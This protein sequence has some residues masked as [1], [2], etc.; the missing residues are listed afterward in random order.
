MMK[1]S[2]QR[3]P[4]NIFRRFLPLFAAGTLLAGIAFFLLFFYDSGTTHRSAEYVSDNGLLYINTPLDVKFTG[5][6]SCRDCHLELYTAFMKTNTARSMYR[7]DTNNIIEEYPQREPVYDAVLDFYYEMI[8]RG[9]KFYQREFRLDATKNVIHERLV[10]AQYVIGSGKNLRMYFYD[11]NG[12]FYELPLTWYAHKKKWDFSPGYKEFGNHRFSRFA[13]SK[14][15]ACHNAHMDASPNALERFVKPYPLG[16]G[17]EA[18]HG[19]GELHVKQELGESVDLPANNARTIVNPIHLSP[20][21]QIDVCQACHL[22]GKAW[23]LRGDAGWFDFRPGMLLEDLWSVYTYDAVH[24][25]EFK[26]ADSGYRFSLSR[27][28]KESHGITT[29]NT[30]HDSHGTFRGTT[31]EFNRQNCQKCHPPESLPGKGSTYAHTERD[32]CVPCH[33]KQTGTKNTLHGVINT[34]HWIRIDAQETTIDWTMHRTPHEMQQVKSIVPALDARDSGASIRKG[35]ALL[36]YYRND[37]RRPVYLDS[38]LAYLTA[39]TELNV[40]DARGF[41]ALGET[42]KELKRLDEAKRALQ[43][44]LALRPSFPEAYYHMGSLFR[45]SGELDSSI[46]YFRLAV[47]HLPGEPSYLEGLG[48]ALAERGITDEAITML[49]RA[50]RIDRQNPA[51]FSYLGTLFAKELGDPASAL[52]Y[53]KERAILDPDAPNVYVDLGNTFAMLGE[54]ALAKQMYER[55]LYYRPDSKAARFNLDKISLIPRR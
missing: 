29:C 21:R 41:L 35:I 28:Y 24:K 5:S 43:K 50:Y 40:R 19:P 11:E 22:Q 53:F 1:Q 51:L 49:Q 14:C 12:M 34:D 7:L 27:C 33:M 3:V 10:E 52:P 48:M 38:A 44:A 9:E 25:E 16:I 18:C 32:D 4:K 26:V 37:D 36:N 47:H 6:E 8:R 17:C 39:G 30:C 31:V 46:H 23:A 55:E 15:L 2:E 45:I 20:Q 42:Y 54:F 13:S